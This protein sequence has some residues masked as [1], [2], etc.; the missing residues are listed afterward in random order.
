MI[1]VDPWTPLGAALEAF[2][3]GR[4]DARLIIDSD[5]F[6]SESVPVHRFY[7]PTGHPLSD[8]EFR[9]LGRCRSRTLEV[10]AGA[11]RHALELQERGVEVTALD[12]DRRCVD[13]MRARGVI[14]PRQGDIFTLAT[15]H[16][17]T[18]LLM[19]NGI[20]IAGDVSGL[21]RLLK[22]FAGL[23]ADGGRLVFDASSLGTV[24]G[25]VSAEAA[26]SVAIGRPDYGEVFFRLTFE[27]LR[28]PWY[29]W[30]F[31]A[32]SMVVDSAAR[33]GFACRV[34]ARGARGAYLMEAIRNTGDASA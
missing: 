6:E 1:D 33:S 26:A 4:H 17:D 24:L 15:G 28:G 25:G 12:I 20:G 13:V 18:I 14:D 8:L 9:A 23:L 22:V 34:L 32:E 16:F 31:P 29:P 30:L 2:H 27:D 21:E 7:R 10:G 3:G 19:M 5:V 11:G